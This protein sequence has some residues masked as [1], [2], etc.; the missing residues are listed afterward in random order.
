MTLLT[1]LTMSKL[2]IYAR[3][4]P[5]PLDETM[6]TLS[7]M[8]ECQRHRYHPSHRPSRPLNVN[9]LTW[10]ALQI[11]NEP[12]T[13]DDYLLST[14][15]EDTCDVPVRE[16]AGRRRELPAR[17][18]RNGMV[19][20]R[21]QPSLRHQIAKKDPCSDGDA[22]GTAAPMRAC[23]IKHETADR[24]C[25]IGGR[26]IF[27]HRQQV[28]QNRLIFIKCR[29]GDAT[30][31]AHPTPEGGQNRPDL[32]WPRLRQDRRQYAVAP[33]IGYEQRGPE[34]ELSCLHERPSPRRRDPSRCCQY[35][36]QRFASIQ[37]SRQATA[38]A[39]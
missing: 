8:S 33:E 26:I 37:P 10:L 35:R 24:R 36:S 6:S 38:S 7:T 30:L 19:S 28:S 27:D 3:T 39:R 34:P 20:P 11:G 5:Q 15:R 31:F 1:L 32:L 12:S 29:V 13:T 9:A 21:W 23:P 25:R 22:L 4:L 14:H 18:T 2:R 16:E 17:E